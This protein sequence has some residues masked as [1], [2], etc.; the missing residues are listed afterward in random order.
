[1]CQAPN[2]LLAMKLLMFCL[3][4]WL[5]AYQDCAR[6][7]G[8]LY[9]FPAIAPLLTQEEQLQKLIKNPQSTPGWEDY[10]SVTEG[11]HLSLASPLRYVIVNT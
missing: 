6:I 9:R 7:Q 4:R 3:F 8:T 1:M 2:R 5:K 10:V 11:A